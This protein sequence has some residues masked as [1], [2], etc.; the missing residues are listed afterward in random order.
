MSTG[1][2]SK[3]K[4]QSICQN[5]TIIAANLVRASSLV[6]AEMALGPLADR[7]AKSTPIEASP[8]LQQDP[9]MRRVDNAS[10]STRYVMEPDYGNNVDMKAAKY[11]QKVRQQNRSDGG[12][13]V[14]ISDSC[15]PPPPSN[16]GAAYKR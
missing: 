16:K 7:N 12:T 5:S 11:I 2:N 8:V 10:R 6:L 1:K 13:A 9:T 14:N 4:N 15:I 3:R